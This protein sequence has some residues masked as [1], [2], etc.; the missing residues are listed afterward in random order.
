MAFSIASDSGALI[1][2]LA[3]AKAHLRVE[4]SDDDALM[5]CVDSCCTRKDREVH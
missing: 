4:V 5:H 3:D 2:S 1:L